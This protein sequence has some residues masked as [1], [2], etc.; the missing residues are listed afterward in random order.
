VAE[1]ELIRDRLVDAAREA[2][3]RAYAPYSNFAVGAAIRTHSGRIFT[4]SNVENA[5]YGLTMCAERVA[6]FAAVAAGERIIESVAVVADTP[7]VTPPC[8]A[9]RQ[10]LFEFGPSTEIV[11]EGAGGV[12]RVWSLANLLPHAFGPNSLQLTSSPD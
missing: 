2:R 10:V 12:R 1:A 9:C 8:G 3:E 4:G 6:V 5:S 11:C 7:D